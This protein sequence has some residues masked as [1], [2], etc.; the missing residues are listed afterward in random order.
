MIAGTL[1]TILCHEARALS[2][3]WQNYELK[4]AWVPKDLREQA[5]LQTWLSYNLNFYLRKKEI[6]NLFNSLLLSFS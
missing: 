5:I 4:G 3:K 2:W 6:S 1:T